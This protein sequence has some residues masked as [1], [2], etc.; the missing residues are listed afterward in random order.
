MA[1]S[2]SSRAHSTPTPVG[3]SILWPVNPKKSQPSSVTSVGRWGD[4]LGAVDQAQRAGGSG[5][6]GELADRE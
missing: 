4:V 6:V 1:S 3:P 5:R 2:S